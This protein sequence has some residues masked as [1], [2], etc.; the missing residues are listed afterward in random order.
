[1]AAPQSKLKHVFGTEMQMQD[2]YG[3]VRPGV[4]H[5][6]SNTIKA[7]NKYFAFPGTM[8]GT[9]CVQALSDKG[10]PPEERPVLF[11]EES[12]VLDVDI[13][14]TDDSLVAAGYEDGSAMV[15]RI[16]AEGLTQNIT[17]AN[18]TLGA[19]GD[20]RRLLYVSFH[21]L[22]ANL[23]MTAHANKVTK[24]W[25]I[26]SQQDCFTLPAHGGAVINASWSNAG[27]LC[28]T[29]AKDK[30]VRVVDP[31]ASTVA[32]EYLPHDGNKS[33]RVAWL[34]NLD[35]LCTVGFTKTGGREIAMTDPRN[36]QKPL[37]TAQLE[38]GTATPLPLY[39]ADLSL[40]FLGG[41]GEGIIR[42]AQAT[43]DKITF[44]GQY[45]NK[46]PQSAV[47]LLPKSHVDVTT[48]EVARV[49]KLIETRHVVVPIRFEVPRQ[50]AAHIF[51]DDL[52]PSTWDRRPTMDAAQFA[53]NAPCPAPT[54]VPVQH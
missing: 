43:E 50:A 17:T 30:K 26:E 24:L 7:N 54:L 25:D 37:F 42:I 36:V 48:C 11:N 35:R 6:D 40:L 3:N 2:C 18:A 32:T 34:G 13:S 47:A 53:S 14:Q 1:M 29:I 21:P 52:Y 38:G 12:T 10:S 45:A 8:N 20:S 22:V 31:R 28:A 49:L 16:P 4:C 33:G 5:V 15:F 44:L 51:Q 19:G 39:D 41:R 9:L 46:D 23:L 27:D